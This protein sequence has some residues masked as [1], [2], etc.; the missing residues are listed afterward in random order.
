MVVVFYQA[1]AV[2]FKNLNFFF[3]LPPSGSYFV[4]WLKVSLKTHRKVFV[5][6]LK[7]PKFKEERFPPSST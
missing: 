3:F 6:F 5:L 4:N 2:I 7:G 1:E